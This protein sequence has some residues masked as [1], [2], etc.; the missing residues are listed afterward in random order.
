MA[1]VWA[2]NEREYL[3]EKIEIELSGKFDCLDLAVTEKIEVEFALRTVRE[4]HCL[5]YNELRQK[6]KSFQPVFLESLFAKGFPKKQS[7]ILV[8]WMCDL[9]TVPGE[10]VNRIIGRIKED[11]E[12][13]MENRTWRGSPNPQ[14]LHTFFFLTK[15]P[16]YYKNFTWPENCHL[17]FTATKQTEFNKRYHDILPMTVNRKSPFVPAGNP[18]I[19]AMLE[20]LVEEINIEWGKTLD[21]VVVGGGKSPLNPDW[22]RSI[23]DQCKAAGIRFHFKS[24]GDWLPF[25]QNDSY[26]LVNWGN[27]THNGDA[28]KTGKKLSRNILDG[29]RHMQGPVVSNDMH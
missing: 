13:R 26:A 14:K 8:G 18:L 4:S 15:S 5:S 3:S 21:W 23:R 29:I 27:H 6:I 12:T 19:F 9:S 28:H 22:V 24:W 1:S 2:K 17:G 20:P 10:W 16:E 25:G 11:N 7:S